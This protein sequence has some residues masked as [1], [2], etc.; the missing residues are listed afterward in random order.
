VHEPAVHH[1]SRAQQ[2]HASGR[3]HAPSPVE[4]RS[5]APSKIGHTGPQLGL[6]DRLPAVPASRHAGVPWTLLVAG[7]L[8]LLVAACSGGA[9]ILIRR[10]PRPPAPDEI[11]A[12]LQE[13]LAEERMKQLQSHQQLQSRQNF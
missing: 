7:V 2:P 6:L 11:E 1:P 5:P 4:T 8:V 9:T 12:E 3:P 13:L 10:R